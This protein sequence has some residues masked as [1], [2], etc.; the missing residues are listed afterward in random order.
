MLHSGAGAAVSV[1]RG[2]RRC[3]A[4]A[5]CL[6]RPRGQITTSSTPSRLRQVEHGVEQDAFHDRAQ[7]ARAGLALDR[8]A[9]DR[10]QRLVREGQLDVLHLE[11][12]LVLLDQRVL[13]LGEDLHQRGFVEILQRRDHRQ[14][15]DEFGDQAELQQILRLDLAEDLARAAV[16]RRLH[17]G[18]EADRRALAARRR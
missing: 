3:R 7:A 8:L 17:L 14:T 5:P 10:V 15:A 13:R 16:V 6:R 11:Q 18:A 2:R 9:G 12:P 4:A 1:A